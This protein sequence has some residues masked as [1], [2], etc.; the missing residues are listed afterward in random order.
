[1]K[2]IR[3]RCDVCGKVGVF[4]RRISRTYGAD[5]AGSQI[6]MGSSPCR[7]TRVTTDCGLSIVKRAFVSSASYSANFGGY[8][9]ADVACQ[10]HAAA[11]GLGGTWMAWVSDSTSSPSVRFTRAAAYRRVDGTLIAASWAGLTSGTLVNS[12]STNEYGVPVGVAEVWTAT[13]PNGTYAGGSCANFTSNSNSAPY[14][15]V[16]ISDR[17]TSDWTT[18]YLQFCDRPGVHLYCFEQ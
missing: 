15:Y 3:E 6:P 2:K 8:L 9:Y 10:N 7:A 13:F 5:S 11:A 16:G 14:T 17:S 4:R 18:V 1:M 12:V